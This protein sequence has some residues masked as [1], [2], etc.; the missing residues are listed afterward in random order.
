MIRCLKLIDQL[1]IQERKE[2]T[3]EEK[4]QEG[5]LVIQAQWNCKDLKRK[6]FK[7]KETLENKVNMG[8]QGKEVK[9]VKNIKE[10]TLIKLCLLH[11]AM[12]EV[13]KSKKNLTIYQLQI[14]N[15]Y[16]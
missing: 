1:E 8:N 3:E 12:S 2:E 6:L 10:S 14:M 16:N 4:E 7:V 9:M 15:W 5:N 13:Q 11:S